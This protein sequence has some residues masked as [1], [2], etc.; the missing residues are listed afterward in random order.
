MIWTQG[1]AVGTEESR[2]M[3]DKLRKDL[4][5]GMGVAWGRALFWLCD[6]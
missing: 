6:G 3:A 5:T 2:L 4:P 1:I